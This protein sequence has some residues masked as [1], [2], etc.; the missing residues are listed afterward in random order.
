MDTNF[1]G[2]DNP[3]FGII[4]SIAMAAALLHSSAGNCAAQP[5][6][7]APQELLPG[8]T[9][10]GPRN[11]HI[12][13]FPRPSENVDVTVNGDKLTLVARDALLSETLSSVAKAFNLSLVYAAP[14]DR[15]ITVALNRQNRYQALDALLLAYNLTWTERDGVIFV[16]VVDAEKLPSEVQGRD[17]TVVELDYVSAVDAEPAV[18]A[19]LSPAG[20][21]W[22]HSSS[23]TDNRQTKEVICFEDVRSNIPRIKDYLAQIDQPPRQVLIEV[24]VLQVEL[25]DDDRHG[26][27]L[28]HLAKIGNFAVDLKTVGMAASGAPQHFILNATAPNVSGLVEA[29]KTATDAKTLASPRIVAMNGQQARLQIGE[30][31]GFR[32]TTTTQTSTLEG[33][34]FIDVGVVLRVTPRI[35]RDGRV[36]MQIR[37]EVSSG[38]VNQLTGLPEEVTTEVQTDV[39]LS[40]GHGT[41]IGGLI[42]ENDDDVVNKYL[43]LGDLPYIGLLF[44]RRQKIKRRQETIIALIPHVLPLSPP[45][46][47]DC[48]QAPAAIEYREPTVAD[49]GPDREAGYTLS[50]PKPTWPPLGQEFNSGAIEKRQSDA[51]QQHTLLNRRP[52]PYPSNAPPRPANNVYQPAPQRTMLPELRRL[53]PVSAE[54]AR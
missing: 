26:V 30:Q 6:A 16:T 46:L 4:C 18:K 15:R 10:P 7:S 35:S 51:D 13:S 45:V 52:Q 39:L 54:P 21:V 27:D 31:L 25:G 19:M 9:A 8:A 29:I 36:L 12:F 48:K 22:L 33:V 34:E 14:N 23:S 44:Q 1:F 32:V 24:H 42:Q 40:S 17:V 49:P 37:P 41:V 47:V 5:A 53:P 2:L 38:N 11:R 50:R 28:A 20:N 43:G 3:Y